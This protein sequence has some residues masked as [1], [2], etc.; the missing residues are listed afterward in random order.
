MQISF[1]QK[2]FQGCMWSSKEPSVVLWLTT[3]VWQ[4]YI[5]MRLEVFADADGLRIRFYMSNYP[6]IAYKLTLNIVKRNVQ[7]R[8]TSFLGWPSQNTT[9]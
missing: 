7:T 2:D 9:N 4:Y 5:L 3:L 6:F 8:C 1:H